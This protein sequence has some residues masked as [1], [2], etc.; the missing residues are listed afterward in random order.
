MASRILVICAALP[1]QQTPEADHTWEICRRLA[2]QGMDIHVLTTRGNGLPGSP[3][4]LYPVMRDWTW[5][6]VPRLASVLRRCSPDAVFLDYVAWMYH[7]HPMI[8]FAPAITKALKPSTRFVTQFENVVPPRSHSRN[9]P[10]RVA[11]E[12]ANIFAGRK[13]MDPVFGTLLRDSNSIVVLSDVHRQRLAERPGR[14]DRR[15]VLLPPP[16]LMR[17]APPSPEDRLR[18][19]ARHRIDEETFLLVYFGY[20]YP[21]KGIDNLLQAMQALVNEGRRLH[22]AVLGTEAHP[23]LG[24]HPTYASDMVR[25]ARERGLENRVTWAGTYRWRSDDVSP[26]LRAADACVL[27]HDYG[28][29][30]NNRALAAVSAHGLPT[31][32]I[33]GKIRE[34]ALR[35]RENLLLGPPH[36]PESL[37]Q[38]LRCLMDSPELRRTLSGG[39]LQLSADWFDWDKTTDKLVAILS[40]PR[41]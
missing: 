4:T 5:P 21:G 27:P 19:R 28:I 18:L 16:P 31:A 13:D 34:D 25:Y 15:W 20:L 2:A 35:D 11:R 14:V 22:L 9:I 41:P 32:A 8:T 30:L 29:Q 39:I 36:A 26:W 6:E 23:L 17:I 33:R 12:L 40:D 37:A 3:Y 10:R 7:D 24:I 38:M 1:P